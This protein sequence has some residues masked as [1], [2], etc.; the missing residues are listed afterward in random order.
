M[1]PI[2]FFLPLALC[3]L[4]ELTQPRKYDGSFHKPWLDGTKYKP[5]YYEKDEI[6]C[7]ALV[8]E[9]YDDK[10]NQYHF[11][12]PS[13]TIMHKDGK[14]VQNEI[15]KMSRGNYMC[16]KCFQLEEVIINRDDSIQKQE[17]FLW[18]QYNF[19]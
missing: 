11:S 4:A 13:K 18:S 19:S 7:G 3:S 8:W 14:E 2:S 17:E 16:F 6:F 10:S 15:L 9:A 5:R 1:L 12:K